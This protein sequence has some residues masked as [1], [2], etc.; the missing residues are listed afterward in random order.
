MTM[1]DV[2]EDHVRKFIELYIGRGGPGFYGQD[3]YKVYYEWTRQQMIR[4][5]L[6]KT[7]FLWRLET[8]YE[9]ERTMRR[10]KVFFLDARLKEGSRG[11]YYKR[12]SD[13]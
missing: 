9:F 11:V 4:P 10:Q 12:Q 13:V 6:G 3:A 2:G 1:E 8:V 7:T 5:Y